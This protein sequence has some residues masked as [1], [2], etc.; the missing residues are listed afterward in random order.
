MVAQIIVG[1]HNCIGQPFDTAY[2]KTQATIAKPSGESK[3]YGVI[4]V[5]TESL[6]ISTLLED[7][8]VDGV[9]VRVGMDANTAIGVVQRRGLNKLR[10]VELDVLW[11]QEQQAR[12]LCSTQKGT[13]A[14][15]SIRPNDETFG[16][17]SH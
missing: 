4:R 7:F 2:S 3:L 11:L 12:R 5:S 10:H 9:K 17:S 8:G 6:G 16:S 1:W 13:R 15:G 14:V